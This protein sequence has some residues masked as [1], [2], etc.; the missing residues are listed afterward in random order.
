MILNPMVLRQMK[1]K[2]KIRTGSHTSEREEG[3]REGGRREG[4]KGFSFEH[5]LQVKG[6]RVFF[7]YILF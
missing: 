7:K 2:S 1:R 3:R 5:L 4:R 6:E